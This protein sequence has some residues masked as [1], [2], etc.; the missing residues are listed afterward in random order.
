MTD[1]DRIAW[2]INNFYLPKKTI[3]SKVI[4]DKTTNIKL[5]KKTYVSFLGNHNE[6]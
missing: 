2:S 4:L 1:C 6:Q 5:E 3:L